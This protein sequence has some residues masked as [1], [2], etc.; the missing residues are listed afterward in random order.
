MQLKLVEHAPP[1]LCLPDSLHIYFHKVFI[2]ESLGVPGSMLQNKEKRK[3]KSNQSFFLK[4]DLSSNRLVFV[5]KDLIS[6]SL[7]A[8]HKYLFS[9]SL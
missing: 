9:G 7:E 1:P 6:L 8:T 3:K 4:E 2:L 5:K